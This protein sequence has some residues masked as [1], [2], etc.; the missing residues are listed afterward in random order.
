MENNVDF[1]SVVSGTKT[2]ADIVMKFVYETPSKKV[3]MH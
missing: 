3:S 1:P 2:I